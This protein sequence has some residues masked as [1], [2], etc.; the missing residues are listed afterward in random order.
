MF[1][2]SK[3]FSNRSP[4][5]VSQL[6][7]ADIQK[8]QPPHARQSFRYRHHAAADDTILCNVQVGNV[9]RRQT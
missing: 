5:L 6:V 1:G 8:L 4:S 7:A 9:K 2:G 3:H